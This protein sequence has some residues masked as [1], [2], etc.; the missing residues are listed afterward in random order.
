MPDFTVLLSY[1]INGHHKLVRWRMVTHCGI[2]G[3]S[4]LVVYMK[5]SSNNQSRTVYDLFLEAA[6]Q[7]GLPSRVRCD[8]GVEN[9]LVAQHMLVV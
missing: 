8:Q 7:H 5:C 3:Y 9:H 2:D 6:H 1:F 4:R